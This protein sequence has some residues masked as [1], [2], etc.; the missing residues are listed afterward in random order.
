MGTTTPP[1][2]IRKNVDTTKPFYNV[3]NI[4]DPV[5]LITNIRTVDHI[6]KFRKLYDGKV[7]RNVWWS[8]LDKVDLNN[9]AYA[10]KDNDCRV[11]Y[12]IRTTFIGYVK[13]RPINETGSVEERS[14]KVDWFYRPNKDLLLPGEK[15]KFTSW[16]LAESIVALNRI[17]LMS[18]DEIC[19][20]LINLD[21]EKPPSA[22]VSN[23]D[24]NF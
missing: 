10:K 7:G 1:P 9:Y 2:P 13:E 14:W 22:A 23:I 3:F 21:N 15:D 19:I 6:D 17:K 18:I 20:D 11:Y 5:F 8:Y 16:H 4:G 12:Y 24:D